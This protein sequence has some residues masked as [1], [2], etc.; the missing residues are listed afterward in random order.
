MKTEKHKKGMFKK[1][2]RTFQYFFSAVVLQSSFSPSTVLWDRTCHCGCPG[3]YMSRK[4]CSSKKS[5]G[6]SYFF[7]KSLLQAC[8]DFERKRNGPTR[9]RTCYNGRQKEQSE[10]YCLSTGQRCKWV[11]FLMFAIKKSP[12]LQ[13]S[14]FSWPRI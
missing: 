14:V 4:G 2:L 6:F 5:F 10:W 8:K 12:F 9:V 7:T 1:A 3:T 11:C 13:L